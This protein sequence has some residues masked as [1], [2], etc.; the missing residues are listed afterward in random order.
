M[1]IVRCLS[2]IRKTP[3]VWYDVGLFLVVIISR[4][5]I[6]DLTRSV[7]KFGGYTKRVYPQYIFFE[8]WARQ[9]NKGEVKGLM[10]I[11]FQM[12]GST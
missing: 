11:E 4:V 3:Q 7:Y 2:E 5:G 10:R 8:Q 1:C 12:S 9:Y 6:P